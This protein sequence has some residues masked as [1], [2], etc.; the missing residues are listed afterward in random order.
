M[1]ACCDSTKNLDMSMYRNN[2]PALAV[3]ATPMIMMIPMMMM[4]YTRD[5]T[6][7]SWSSLSVA[8]DNIVATGCY[9]KNTRKN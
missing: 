4:I 7:T 9:E 1:N 3:A 2:Y 6:T 5:I 8:P